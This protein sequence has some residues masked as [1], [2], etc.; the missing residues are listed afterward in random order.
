[1]LFLSRSTTR[2]SGRPF[3][4]TSITFRPFG[5]T[6]FGD[7]A[8]PVKPVTWP[9]RDGEDEMGSSVAGVKAQMCAKDDANDGDLVQRGL[10]QGE[11]DHGRTYLLISL[12]SDCFS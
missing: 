11:N 5:D 1:M 6:S 4:G 3:A 10:R 12:L 7:R 9:A 2:I 8:E